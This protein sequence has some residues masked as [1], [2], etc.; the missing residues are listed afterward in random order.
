M[1]ARII[2]PDEMYKIHFINAV[3]F[4]SPWEPP[5]AEEAEAKKPE[6]NAKPSPWDHWLIEDGDE[7]CAGLGV[8]NTN[9]RFDGHIVPMGGIGGVAT[10]PQHRRKG[11]IRTGLSAA[12]NDLLEKGTVFSVLYPFSRAYYRQFGFEDGATAGV[13]NIPFSA[14]R[15]AD[16]GGTIELIRPDGDFAPVHQIYAACAE[17]WNLSFTE[18]GFLDSLAKRNYMNHKHYLYIW[19]D[20]TGT[21][22]GLIFFSKVNGVMDCTHTFAHPGMLLFRDMRALTALLRFAKGFAADYESIRFAVPQ[23]VRIQSLIS[24]GNDV[25]CELLYTCMARL[26]NAPRALQLCR[27]SGEGSIVISVADEYVGHNRG[28]W[29]VTFN[30]GGLNAVEKTDAP[31]D[32]ELPVGDLT[33]LLLGVCAAEDI[34]MMPNVKVNNPAAPLE[35]IFMHK[36]CH[37]IDLF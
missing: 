35:K 13:W 32:V 6:E 11:A 36:P 28:S 23:G 15:P 14:I 17:N 4:E 7:F 31:A 25:K 21:P 33:Q 1:R 10:L 22:A 5:K 24:E 19:R 18:S 29:K 3:A 37:I 30:P 12:M 34:P 9:I 8:L 20:E 27:T 16:M 26:I 2:G